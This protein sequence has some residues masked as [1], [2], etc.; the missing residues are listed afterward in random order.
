[1]STL[2]QDLDW[3]L[4]IVRSC[5]PAEDVEIVDGSIYINIGH[6]EAISIDPVITPEGRVWQA[7]ALAWDRTGGVSGERELG[8]AQLLTFL[9]AGSVTDFLR[10]YREQE[11]EL[12]AMLR[13]MP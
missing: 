6:R 8:A 3:G 7:E 2:S 4:R 11:A 9:L 13:E 10:E 1:M 5:Q 12:E